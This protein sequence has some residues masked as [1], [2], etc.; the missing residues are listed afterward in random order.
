MKYLCLSFALLLTSPAW[1]QDKDQPADPA[2]D[3]A[4]RIKAGELDDAAAALTR[5]VRRNRTDRTLN[6]LHKTLAEKMAEAGN[7]AGAAQQYSQFFLARTTPTSVIARELGKATECL[8]NAIKDDSDNASLH[9][10]R[11]RFASAAARTRQYKPAAEQYSKLLDWQLDSEANP[12]SVYSTLASLRLYLSRAGR[13]KDVLPTID[14][15]EKYIAG[16]GESLQDRTSLLQVHNIKSMALRTTDSEA[17]VA[18]LQADYD[19]AKAEYAK[20]KSDDAAELAAWATYHLFSMK[21]GEE[22]NTLFTEH[23]ELAKQLAMKKT[24]YNMVRNFA[25]AGTSLVAANVSSD[26]DAAAKMIE[27]LKAEMASLEE[28]NKAYS[29]TLR[30]YQSSLS[31]YE[32]RIE[33]ARKLLAMVGKPAPEFDVAAW[34]TEDGQAPDLKGKVV[35]VDFWAIWCGPCVATFPH[36]KHLQEEYGDRGFQVVGVTRYYNYSWDDEKK[37][38]IRGPRGEKG[39]A[40]A[41]HTAIRNF[42]ASHDLSHPSFVVPEGSKMQSNFGVSGIPHAVVIDRNGNIQLVKVGSGEAN[43]K[44]IEAK[45]RELLSAGADDGKEVGA[46]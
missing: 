4:A 11:G 22:K 7:D 21:S 30:S 39:D 28:E 46:Q 13:Q 36:L 17:A 1:S 14:R 15:V 26:P 8:E 34:A 42:L 5:A 33:S 19:S 20:E 10:M 43:S 41:E 32:G 29:P 2:T 40:D 27:S 35:L 44:A 9:M 38:A 3:I 16:R 18:L 24:N 23:Q 45:V 25:S 31:R 6:R 12:R 37:K